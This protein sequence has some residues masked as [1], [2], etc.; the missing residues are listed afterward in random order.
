MRFCCIAKY[1]YRILNK[2]SDKSKQIN[3]S[4]QVTYVFEKQELN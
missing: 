1:H 3:E 2:R 4:R